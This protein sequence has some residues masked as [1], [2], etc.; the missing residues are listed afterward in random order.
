[1]RPSSALEMI[2]LVQSFID[3][4]SALTIAHVSEKIATVAMDHQEDWWLPSS[5]GGHE[6]DHPRL[7]PMNLFKSVLARFFSDVSGKGWTLVDNGRSSRSLS[8]E[9][10]A[11]WKV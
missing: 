6:V 3:D 10:G 1:M 4:I 7:R 8:L 9:S 11:E 5:R 2:E